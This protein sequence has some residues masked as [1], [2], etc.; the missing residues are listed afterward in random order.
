MFIELEKRTKKLGYKGIGLGIQE[1]QEE[2]YAK[3]GYTGSMLIQ[4]EKYSIDDLRN[5]LES[6]NNKNWE[7]RNTN[8]YDG[9][10]NQLWLNVSILD[11]D[12]KKKFEVDLGD[13]WTQII[14]CKGV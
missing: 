10:I 6:L 7:L 8:I 1:G 14:V 9:Y 4:S 3:L 5:Y 2:F 12:L 13:C 11:K